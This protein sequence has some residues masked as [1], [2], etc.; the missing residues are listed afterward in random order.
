MNLENFKK[1][2][3]FNKYLIS[4][5]GDIYSLSRKR[6]LSISHNWAGYAI[7][8]L[9]DDNGFRAPRKIHR[10]VYI[11]FIGPIEKDKVIDHIDDNKLNNHFT[12]LQQISPSENSIKSFIS[13][14]N[15][16]KLIVNHDQIKSICE[17][18]ENNISVSIIF[19]NL[20][21]DYFENPKK[22]ISL[23]NRL[24]LGKIYKNI[25]KDYNIQHYISSINK[26]DVKLNINEVRNIYLQL[27]NNEKPINLAKEYKVSFSTICKIRDKKTWKTLT[28]LIDN[29]SSTTTL[30]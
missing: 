21:I 6:L 7:A 17:M 23:V 14:K 20:G 2:P 1:I 9:V 30:K 19:K 4:P 8:T 29:D 11:A 16:N 25:S 22:Y 28:D 24:K 13:G 27:K 3:N 26:K 12:N 15:K 18:M 10:L 5:Y